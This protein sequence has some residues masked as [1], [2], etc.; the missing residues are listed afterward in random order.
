MGK[1]VV[2]DLTKEL[3]GDNH[4]VFFDNFFTSLN[5]MISLRKQNIYA[6][7]T[8]R[9]GRVGLPRNERKDRDMI[10]GESDSRTS[11]AGVSWLKWK[12]RRSILFL[13]N[14]HDPSIVATVSR[15]EKDGTTTEIA[16]PNS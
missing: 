9:H 13:F 5:L 2:E 10:R 3:I 1:R 12:D 14:C 7:G 6:C 4:K 11:Y 8:V 15:K 16:C